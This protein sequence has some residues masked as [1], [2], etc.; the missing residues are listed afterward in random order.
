MF[1]CLYEDSEHALAYQIREFLL[2]L[3]EILAISSELVY[4]YLSENIRKP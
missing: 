1:W 3:L 2:V 4:F